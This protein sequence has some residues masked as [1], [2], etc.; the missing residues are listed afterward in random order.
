MN[1]ER[2]E[3]CKQKEDFGAKDYKSAPSSLELLKTA[4]YNRA[5]S[6]KLGMKWFKFTVYFRLL[7]GSLIVYFNSLARYKYESILYGHLSTYD[8]YFTVYTAVFVIFYLISISV[9]LNMR[10]FRKRGVISYFI[11]QYA[12][13]LIL[14]LI[15]LSYGLYSQ[16][17]VSALAAVI[18]FIPEFIYFKKRMHLFD[19]ENVNINADVQTVTDDTILTS[20]TT[21]NDEVVDNT[22]NTAP[23][24]LI[25]SINRDLIIKTSP[26]ENFRSTNKYLITF[27]VGYI[28][29]AIIQSIFSFPYYTVNLYGVI[30]RTGYAPIYSIEPYYRLDFEKLLLQFFA[31]GL[32]LTLVYLLTSHKHRLKEVLGKIKKIK[33]RHFLICL[34]AIYLVSAVIHSVFYMPFYLVEVHKEDSKKSVITREAVAEGYAPITD[35]NYSYRFDSKKEN[36]DTYKTANYPKLFTH[37]SVEFLVFAIIYLL[38]YKKFAV[39]ADN[40]GRNIKKEK[41]LSAVDERTS[42]TL[43]KYY[44]KKVADLS[45]KNKEYSEKQKVYDEFLTFLSDCNKIN[46]DDY[47]ILKEMLSISKREDK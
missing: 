47:K 30:V 4:K 26:K 6:E 7:A 9:F 20:E 31:E 32:I 21:K 17:Y 42:D 35:I 38:T 11:S 33:R 16:T 13:C 45:A 29:L 23:Q 28:L 40:A 25:K 34:T 1:F 43:I 44:R 39:T 12:C 36:G 22:V 18:C 24:V 15:D 5:R 37:L 19:G 27:I 2:N 14:C 3:D 10:S 8:E 41:R 46:S